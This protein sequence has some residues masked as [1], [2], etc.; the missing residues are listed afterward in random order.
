METIY[1]ICSWMKGQFPS[2]LM[3]MNSCIDFSTEEVGWG[4]QRCMKYGSEDNGLA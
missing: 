3:M 4:K 1:C 2:K